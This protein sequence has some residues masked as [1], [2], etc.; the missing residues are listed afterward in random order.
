LAVPQQIR[1]S[2]QPLYNRWMRRAIWKQ[3]AWFVTLTFAC[4]VIAAALAPPNRSAGMIV[5]ER[6]GQIVIAWKRATATHLE[7]LDGAW[8]TAIEIPP[9]LS[10]ITYARRTGDVSVLLASDTFEDTAHFVSGEAANPAEMADRIRSLS[11]QAHSARIET[12]SDLWRISQMQYSARKMIDRAD[13]PR[14]QTRPQPVIRKQPS[15]TFW[16]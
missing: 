10:G 8:R 9:E 14:P 11:D 2:V 5:R 4:A 16:R 3:V 15:M 7:I 6:N 13:P 12:E 1:F